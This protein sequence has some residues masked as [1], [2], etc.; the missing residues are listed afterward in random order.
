MN[1]GNAQENRL[2]VIDSDKKYF[3][4]ADDINPND[5]NSSLSHIINTISEKSVVLDVGCSYGYV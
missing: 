2:F 1:L 3:A 5:K 4:T